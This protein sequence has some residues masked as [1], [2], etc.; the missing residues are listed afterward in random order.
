MV[1]VQ[2]NQMEQLGWENK[3]SEIRGALKI[4]K[5]WEFVLDT[6]VH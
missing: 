2:K 1:V 6:G 4:K 5:T 3:G